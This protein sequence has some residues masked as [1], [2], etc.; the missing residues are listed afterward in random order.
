MAGVCDGPKREEVRII[1]P[2]STGNEF[3]ISKIRRVI[4]SLE[5]DLDKCF[6]LWF[7]VVN[8]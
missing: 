7:V 2:N 4:E 5:K 3:N 1:R 6:R 8:R